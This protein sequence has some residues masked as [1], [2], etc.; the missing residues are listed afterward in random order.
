MKHIP[1][2]RIAIA[3]AIMLAGAIVAGS[4][5]YRQAVRL[6]TATALQALQSTEEVAVTQEEGSIIF[7][8]TNDAGGGAEAG[9]I[10]YAGGFVDYRAYAPVAAEIAARGHLVALVPAPLNLAFF[11]VNAADAVIEQHP[12]VE[13][14]AVGGHSLGGVAAASYAAQHSEV[15][16]IVFWASYPAGEA[17]REREI[18]VLSLSASRDGLATP[19]DISESRTLLPDDALFVE[20]EGGN[21]AQ[22]GSY[23]PQSGDN[24]ATISPEAQWAEIAE[25]TGEFLTGINRNGE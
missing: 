19:A 1:W 16:G 10:L 15:D 6:P 25:A 5:Y 21:H 11:N 13:G 24:A 7:E 4:I 3:M 23:G 22:F 18:A 14:W 17:L 20:I 12:D 2:K 8:A 9:L